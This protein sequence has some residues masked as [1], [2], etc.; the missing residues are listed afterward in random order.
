VDNATHVGK[1]PNGTPAIV[2]AAVPAETRRQ[3]E[4]PTLDNAASNKRSGPST[5]L[6]PR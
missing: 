1:A 4:E 5:P 2:A 3:P 6:P